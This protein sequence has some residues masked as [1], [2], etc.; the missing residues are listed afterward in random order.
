MARRRVSGVPVVLPQGQFAG[1]PVLPNDVTSAATRELGVA[2]SDDPG[3][4]LA[5][6][7][8]KRTFRG[9]GLT[10][11]TFTQ[12]QGGPATDPVLETL[13]LARIQR[14]AIG[15]TRGLPRDPGVPTEPD[16]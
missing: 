3:L 16:A 7:R 6:S 12:P 8:G 4:R 2:M 14:R 9:G 11:Q 5:A 10:V 1:N 15:T 13:P